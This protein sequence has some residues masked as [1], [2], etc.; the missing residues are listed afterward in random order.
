M[1]P[2]PVSLAHRSK[3]KPNILRGCLY[4]NFAIRYVEAEYKL[5]IGNAQITQLSK[6][7][8]TGAEKG[9]FYLPK[10]TA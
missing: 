5:E 4:A 3:S 9:I 7:I 6:A 2:A 10:G 8:A 1:K